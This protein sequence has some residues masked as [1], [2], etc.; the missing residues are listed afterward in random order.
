MPHEVSTLYQAGYEDG[1]RRGRD[2]GYQA[3]YVEGCN[4]PLQGNS[5][6]QATSEGTANMPGSRKRWLL[7]LP[8]EHCGCFLYSEETECP[9]CKVA[10]AGR[11]P[12]LRRLPAVSVAGDN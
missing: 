2:A 9:H 7:G 5:K 12:L 11:T 3:G 8:C 6:P 1:Y 10:T 4:R